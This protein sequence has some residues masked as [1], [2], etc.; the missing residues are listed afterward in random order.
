MEAESGVEEAEE[1]E[2]DGK[3]EFLY[4]FSCNAR[5]YKLRVPVPAPFKF[6]GGIGS[7]AE[8]TCRLIHA[9]NL[10]CYLEQ[11]LCSQLEAFSCQSALR[12]WDEEGDKAIAG[13]SVMEKVKI[14]PLGWV[15]RSSNN[16]T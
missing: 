10:P 1:V 3:C 13:V 7:P 14:I 11:D 6:G 5:S 2:G 15:Q 9:H 16:I 4:Q 12:T 8:L